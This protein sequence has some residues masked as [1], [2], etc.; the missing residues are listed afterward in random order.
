[1]HIKATRSLLGLLQKGDEEEAK[2]RS[3]FECRRQ[4]IKVL[5]QHLK[6]SPDQAN[7]LVKDHLGATLIE[8]VDLQRHQISDMCF[9][10]ELC[11]WAKTDA[12]KE[13]TALKAKYPVVRNFRALVARNLKLKP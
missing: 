12:R 11:E 2:A 8:L 1:M 13:L 4:R 5:W 9:N 6:N 7:E 10:H 3:E